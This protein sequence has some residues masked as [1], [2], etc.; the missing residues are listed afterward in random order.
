MN[1]TDPVEEAFRRHD[2]QIQYYEDL[3]EYDEEFSQLDKKKYGKRSRGKNQKLIDFERDVL[4]F[5]KEEKN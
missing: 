4:E 1:I 3:R 5:I 2:S